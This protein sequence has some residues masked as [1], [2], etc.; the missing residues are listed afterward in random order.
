MSDG[1][2]TEVR[3]LCVCVSR[4]CIVLIFQAADAFADLHGGSRALQPSQSSTDILTIH[5]L[6]LR[7]MR[8]HGRIKQPMC[9][10]ICECLI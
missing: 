2:H 3:S 10:P 1:A 5:C 4:G 9:S 6:Q 8:L 7:S